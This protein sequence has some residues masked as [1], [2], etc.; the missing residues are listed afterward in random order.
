M[1]PGELRAGVENPQNPIK[2]TTS[3]IDNKLN[4]FACRVEY[5]VTRGMNK[6]LYSPSIA[7]FLND[8]QVEGERQRA[9]HGPSRI[10]QKINEWMDKLMS[11]PFMA[12]LE[13]AFLDGVSKTNR[14]LD[15]WEKR[16]NKP[17]RS[18]L[19]S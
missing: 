2:R 14:Q 18:P 11:H 6:I 10:D 15:D 5:Y 13:N 1:E 7:S 3:W 17:P 16:H 19:F 12:S 8:V 9:A 4:D